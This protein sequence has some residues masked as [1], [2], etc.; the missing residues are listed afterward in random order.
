MPRHIYRLASRAVA[1]TAALGAL[2]ACANLAQVPPGAPM[3]EVTSQFGRPNFECTRADGTHRVIWTTQPSGQ[4][5]WGTDLTADGRTEQIVPIL[6][7]PYF[8]QHLA[9]GMTAEQVQCEF[10]PPADISGVGLPSVRE[11]V[12]AYRYKQ[13]GVW[14][15]LMYVY[16]GRDGNSV[17]RFHPGPDP[18]YD[19][20]RRWR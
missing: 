13:S 18:L 17:T 19:E 11:T 1:L 5:A 4:Y 20:D 8:K 12:W 9:Q 3:A 10:G 7:D 14:N 6:T 16:M 15:S 2:S